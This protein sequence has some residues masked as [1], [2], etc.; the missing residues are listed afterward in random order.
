M[1]ARSTRSVRPASGSTRPMSTR[2]A[3]VPLNC[4]VTGGSGYIAL[5]VVD[6]L[7]KDG[8]KVRATVRSLEN[9]E[10]CGPL[11]A[12]GKNPDQ[13]TL[14]EADLL[15]ADSLKE[16]VKDIDMVFHVASPFPMVGVPLENEDI[17]MKPAV[18]GTENLL[19]A[20]LDTKVKRVVVTSSC[21][22]LFDEMPSDTNFTEE[23][24]GDQEKAPHPYNKSK[25]AAEK[26]AWA[27]VKERKEKNEA[28]FELATVLPGLVMGPILSKAS[29]T[30]GSI[31]ASLFNSNTPEKPLS[32]MYLPVSDVRD[33]ALAHLRAATLPEA[34]DHRHIVCSQKEFYKLS[35]VN[36]VLANEFNP[37]GMKIATEPVEEGDGP[38]KGCTVD[39][40]R[41]TD[42]L[43]V[44]PTDFKKC[45]ID[46][47]NS[48]IELGLAKL[49]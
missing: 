21:V 2:A 16:A 10:K 42:V 29:C 48:Y 36:T 23:N 25:I 8:H 14:V 39:T 41:M 46:M 30:S 4:L 7:L 20:C 15:N 34:K 12:L 11:K 18:E 35:D 1:S 45:L 6:H 27:F 33:V 38:G 13:L 22:T 32:N 44:A 24:F 43:K 37:K 5:H 40:T 17:C 31:F 9:E 28:V 49:E 47:G 3:V 26:F 19:K